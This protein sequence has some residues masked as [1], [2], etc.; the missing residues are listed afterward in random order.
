VIIV[1]IGGD[2]IYWE[3]CGFGWRKRGKV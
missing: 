2:L 3:E 1:G